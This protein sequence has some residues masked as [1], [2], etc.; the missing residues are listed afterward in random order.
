MQG[1][2]LRGELLTKLIDLFQPFQQ[3][4]SGHINLQFELY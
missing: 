2:S 4:G 3:N 1:L